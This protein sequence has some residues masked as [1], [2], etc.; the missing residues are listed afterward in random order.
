MISIQRINKTYKSSSNQVHAVND[1]NLEFDSTGMVAIFGNSGCGKTTLLNLIGGLDNV[2]N[3]KI[4][5]DN[6]KMDVNNDYVRNK[7]IGYI[8]QNYNLNNDETCYENVANSLRLC[9]IKD[10]NFI[11]NRVEEVLRLV[12]MNHYRKRYPDTLS[13]GQQQRIAIARALVKNPKV[14]LADEPTGNLDEANTAIVIELLKK[15]SKNKLVILVTHE[16]NL[17]KNYCDQIVN[18]QDG[19]VISIT[20]NQG[21]NLKQ[22]DKN[23]IYLGEYDKKEVNSDNV[24]IQYYGNNLPEKIRLKIINNNGRVYL[25]IDEGDIRIIDE[26][27]EIKLKEGIFQEKIVEED[28]SEIA[29]EDIQDANRNEYG[30]MFNLSNSISEGYKVNFKLRKKKNFMFRFI[31]FLFSIFVL[32][33]AGSFGTTLKTVTTIKRQASD[34]IFYVYTPNLKTLEKANKMVEDKDV[35]GVDYTR[36]QP[37]SPFMGTFALKVKK[38]NFAFFDNGGFYYEA[39]SIDADN[40]IILDKKIIDNKR[41][42]AGNTNDFKNGD[43]IIS[44]TVAD[45]LLENSN[46]SYI[47]KYSDLLYLRTIDN[48]YKIR[49]IVD[50]STYAIYGNEIDVAKDVLKYSGKV[51]PSSNI[52]REIGDN[53][54]VLYGR[55][56]KNQNE[57]VNEG[58]TVNLNGIDILITESVNQPQDAV[59]YAQYPDGIY[60]SDNNYIKMSRTL[61]NV[62]TSNYFIDEK[63]KIYYANDD[64]YDYTYSYYSIV[65][66]TNPSKTS[67]YIS[68][69]FDDVFIKNASGIFTE[70][71]NYYTPDD[72]YSILVGETQKNITSSITS[73]IIVLAV[74]ALSMYFVIRSSLISRIKEVGILR[75]IGVSKRNIRFKFFIEVLVLSTLTILVGLIVGYGIILFLSRSEIMKM[76]LYLPLW[77]FG[78]V[79]VAL[80]SFAVLFGM[81]PVFGL[82]RKT[83]SSILAKYDI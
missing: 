29:L 8:F 62:S 20:K 40:I 67:K 45:A 54:G 30:K 57:L 61:G 10:N 63:S 13:G 64:D 66:S 24:S 68:E 37:Q 71:R 7:Y 65:H 31:L 33:T 12:G 82:V 79:A 73:I 47:S 50:E 14:I 3:G 5:I 60:V 23:D 4:L 2:D 49:A 39:P 53:E 19:K 34:D 78:I 46:V 83:P 48:Q 77:L 27:S 41:L 44:R 6:Q 42:I 81:L 43:I 56:Y 69:N 9:G 58:D 25:K 72:M 36:L 35:T 74:M 21:A 16:E 18:I 22:K 1:V 32:F 76:M 38:G 80:F 17:V 11:S 15:I 51:Y 59:Y 28:N 75:A 70:Y 26:S 52:G 55:V